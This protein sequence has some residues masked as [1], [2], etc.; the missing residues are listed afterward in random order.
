MKQRRF[1]L[2]LLGVVLLLHITLIA[3]SILEVAI[4]S[5]LINPG[6]D[7]DFYSAHAMESGPWVSV[8]F[9]SAF[10]FLLVRRYM[11]RFSH[12]QLTYAIALPVVYIIIDLLLM[13][14]AGAS[15]TSLVSVYLLSNGIKLL[16]SLAAYFIYRERV[17]QA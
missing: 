14:A 13:V 5:Y 2:K 12:D 17:Q 11:K 1:W 4:Y 8:I 9:G 3:L 16:A 10:C 7:N 6:H 15:I